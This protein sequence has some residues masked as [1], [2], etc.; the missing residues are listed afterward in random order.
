[1]SDTIL[2]G[3]IT[4]YYVTENRQKRL[5]WSGS[6]TGTR[7]VKETYLALM[8][9]FDGITQMREGEPMSA[10]TPT[11]YTLGQ[12]D[13]ND[14]DPWFIDKTTVE[15]LTGALLRTAGW[16]RAE[17]TD[18]GI[19]RVPITG[20]TLVDSDIGS[21][22]TDTDTAVGT[23][24]DFTALEAWIRPD[25]SD[26]DDSFSLNPT[27]TL[28]CN[29]NST[30]QN[31]APESGASLWSNP[32][33][34]GSL[35]A[36]THIY[37]Y[38]NSALLTEYK[39]T[40]IESWWTRDHF[41]ILVSVQE[42][43][44]L[45]DEGFITVLARQYSKGD[46]YFI[47]DLSAGIRTPI[48]FST[49]TDLDNQTGYLTIPTGAFGGGPFTVGEE[50]TDSDGAAGIVTAQVADTS[51]DY[52]LLDNLADFA[53]GVLVTGSSSG[54]SAT[55][56]GGSSAAGPAALAGLSI[57]HGKAQYDITEDGV[58]E[59]YSI[60]IDVSDEVL[61]AAWEWIKYVTRRGNL[62]TGNTDGIAAESYLGN[63]YRV[64]YSTIDGTG[65]V[66]GE[67]VT[68]LVTGATGTVVADHDTDSDN[69]ILILRNSRGTFSDTDAIES[70]GDSDNGVSAPFTVTPLV[71]IKQSPF[72]SF[73]GG[74][75][76]GADGV[77]LINYVGA[78]ANSFQLTDDLGA[79]VVAP[80]KITL[81]IE[82]TRILDE[83]LFAR[84][85]GGLLADSEYSIETAGLA[86]STIKVDPNIVTDTP[87]TGRVVVRDD[88]AGLEHYYRYTSK[89][90]TDT[91]TLFD[92]GALAMDAGSDSDTIVDAAF[93]FTTAQVGDIIL[94]STIGQ[95]TYIESIIDSDNITVFPPIS[96]QA[97]TNAYRIGA[98]VQA[99]DTDDQ[100]WVPFMLLQE[101]AG[102]DGSPGEEET[103][104]T[105]VSPIPYIVR[106][107][108]STSGSYKIKPFVTTGSASASA[109]VSAIRNPETIV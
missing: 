84:T 3:D 56:S 17:G 57:T 94:N 92:S 58:N 28:N 31:G 16:A 61:T 85:S 32:F 35:A 15:H 5:E 21:D 63:D 19:I 64:L 97:D 75:F 34:I 6:A 55:P 67:T 65:L 109:A 103:S 86:S 101:T 24:L 82:N 30:T 100:V 2:S 45:I 72:G 83:L 107:R 11:D 87:A 105:Y 26:T 68:Q 62:A 39:D 77:V 8:D 49:A 79:V 59:F 47:T 106:V 50:I 76:F 95:V 43:G 13:S 22:I 37:V 33:S 12:I 40:D 104:V 108:N 25:T 44:V 41:D 96:G 73:A 69:Y 89:D 36:N 4:V 81:K 74:T 10:A 78:D 70:D 80:T 60:V 54:A 52:Y 91:F 23:L 48:P 53:S 42:V 46:D 20:G 88:A 1:M 51:L 29:S 98:T 71:P 66:E 9:L 14:P 93:D 99:Y 27:G 18:P 7:T 102:T 38:Q 90:A